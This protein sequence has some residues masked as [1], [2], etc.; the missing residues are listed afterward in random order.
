MKCKDFKK[1]LAM[2]LAFSIIF[3]V[4]G[5]GA[6][7][8]Q[9]NGLY[10]PYYNVNDEFFSTS[11]GEH[12]FGENYTELVSNLTVARNNDATLTAMFPM[13][14]VGDVMYPDFIGGIYYSY[15]GNMVVQIV[16][17]SEAKRNT[18]YSDVRTALHEMED[19]VIEYVEASYNELN[20]IKNAILGLV[21]DDEQCEVIN[22]MSALFV[23]VSE[24]RLFVEL[25]DYRE[26]TIVAFREVVYCSPLIVFKEREV[27]LTTLAFPGESETSSEAIVTEGVGIMPTLTGVVHP[28]MPMLRS[29]WGYRARRNGREG[30][31]IAAHSAPPGQLGVV[32]NIPANAWAFNGVIDAAFVELNTGITASNISARGIDILTTVRTSFRENDII[33]K[34]GNRTGLSWGRVTD[35]NWSGN[36]EDP[37]HGTRFFVGLVDTNVWNGG[38]DSGGPVFWFII[39][40][41]PNVGQTAG[42]VTAGTQTPSNRMIFSRAD[43]INSAFGLT[44]F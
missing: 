29:S 2:L 1:I 44:R 12:F 6:N 25:V 20:D 5:V 24:N 36:I 32:G 19:V 27:A 16:E 3:G 40:M 14:R 7:E 42:I 39:P 31:V 26:E 11:L 13:N 23:R 43:R 17:C 18:L 41:S 22:N 30:V 4:V 35:P 38:G 34:D 10:P 33:G 15:D 37:N 21:F 8:E 9:N 28:G